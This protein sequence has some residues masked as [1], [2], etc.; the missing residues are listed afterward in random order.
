MKSSGPRDICRPDIHPVPVFG[1]ACV[2]FGSCPS[3]LENAGAFNMT[4]VLV[5]GSCGVW[6]YTAALAHLFGPRSG[7]IACFHVQQVYTLLQASKSGCFRPGTMIVHDRGRLVSI[8]PLSHSLLHLAFA[9]GVIRGIQ[10]EKLLGAA[11]LIV[12]RVRIISS[13]S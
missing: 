1:R 3:L 2:S 4:G 11:R 8:S 7:W 5:A 9:A 6:L 13:A 12:H 10:F